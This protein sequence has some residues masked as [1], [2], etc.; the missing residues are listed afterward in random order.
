MTAGRTTPQPLPLRAFAGGLLALVAV[1]LEL[2]GSVA[3]DAP[4]T[5]YPGWLV[6]VAWPT[7]LRVVWWL[8]AAAGAGTAVAG[9]TAHRPRAARVTGVVLATLPFVV[10][11]AGVGLGAQW[12]TWH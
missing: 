1:G 5:A 8:A 10:F 3:G 2:L 11:A 6:P 9:L 4:T 7:A 12:A